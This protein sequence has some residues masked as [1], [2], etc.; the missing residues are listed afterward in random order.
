MKIL[1]KRPLAL[2]LCI[3][4]GGF[5]FFADFSNATKLIAV[6]ISLTCIGVIFIFDNLI[7]GRKPIVIISFVALAVSLMLSFLW[8]A[9][10]YP[11]EFYDSTVQITAKVYDIDNSGNY[12]SVVECRSS[13]IDGKRDKHTLVVYMEKETARKLRKYDVITFV[14]TVSPF[15][16]N[17]NGFDG[18]SY[19]VSRGYSAICEDV[20]ELTI[21]GNKVDKLDSFFSNLRLKLSNK[22]KLRTDYETG[23]LLSALILGDRSTLNGNTK[24]NFARLGISHILALSGMHLA[25]LS[26]AL[27]FLLKKLGINKKIRFAVMF[28][29]VPFYM[30]LTGFS[31]SVLRS[32]LMLLISSALFLLS[33]KAD[34]VTSLLLSVFLIVLF[35]PTSV[36]DMS[37]WLSA[38][39]TLGVV[40]FSEIAEKSDKDDTRI[41][42]LLAGL[43]NACL[44]SV[45]AFAATFAVT[46][47]RFNGFSVASVI[48][49][50]IFSFVIQLFIYLGLLLLIFGGIIP[51]G[52]IVIVFS[53]AILWLAEKISSIKFIY[54]S[55]DSFAVRLLIVLFTVFFFAFLLF[56]LKHKKIGITI[57]V[58]I[59]LSIFAVAEMKTMG[60]AYDDGVIYAPSESGDTFLV[61]SNADISAIYSGKAFSDNGRDILNYLTDE[62]VTY[63]DNF[64]FASYSYS[65]MDF[66]NVLIDGVKV[67]R[68]MLPRPETDEEINQAEGISY[69]LA[70]HGAYLEFYDILEYVELGAYRYRLIEKV[71]YDYGKYPA[72]VFEIVS[73]EHHYTY[74]SVCEYSN[75]P[76]SAKAFVV[77][78][79]NLII[80]S[81]GNTKYYIFDMRLSKIESIYYYEEGRLTEDAEKH[82]K[83]KGAS[84]R[85]TKTPIK[86]FD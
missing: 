68:V 71:D 12:S 80:G 73:G 39:A 23:S 70:D 42:K 86:I 38:F 13:E 16:K 52:K 19:Y 66:L 81:I 58:V 69:L 30:A 51:F 63:L 11:N 67:E 57:I 28:A 33:K 32:G 10:F 8:S 20:S 9:I 40:A 78:A 74:L 36:Y 1:E 15:S 72:N 75:L 56:E 18:R 54:V 46:A 64:I 48:T 2:I 59:M 21:D 84:V 47:T 29:I 7:C 37:L 55:M 24:L 44:V 79:K 4:L 61:R 17:D 25:I 49:T 31:A 6:A 3:M 65:T 41:K 26:L 53:N 60:I 77:N 22:L 14:A 5:S 35:S 45:F 76:A 83:E 27:H 50:L 82:Y 85:C 43:K 62:T 34:A